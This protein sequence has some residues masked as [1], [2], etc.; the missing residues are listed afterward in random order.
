MENKEINK[1]EEIVLNIEEI[2]LDIKHFINYNSSC[3]EEEFNELKDIRNRIKRIV[4]RL[5]NK[6]TYKTIKVEIPIGFMNCGISVCNHF[7]ADTNDGG[8]WDTLK[9]PLPEPQYRWNIKSYK[10]DINNP[11]KLIVVLIDKY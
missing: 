10:E 5:K 11:K 7:I 2:V 8:N 6:N 9:F 4:Y 1:L 3:M